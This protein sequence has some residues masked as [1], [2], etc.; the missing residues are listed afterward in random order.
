MVE[1]H[2]TTRLP[3]SA[4]SVDPTLLLRWRSSLQSVLVR[5]DLLPMT[6]IMQMIIW[7]KKTL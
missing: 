6:M 5:E 3:V 7:I 1:E 2:S 4:E